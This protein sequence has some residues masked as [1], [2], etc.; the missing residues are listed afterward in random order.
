[1]K[2]ELLENILKAESKAESIISTAGIKL[3]YSNA[4]IP[5]I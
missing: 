3:L 2:D 4:S 5:N 1:M